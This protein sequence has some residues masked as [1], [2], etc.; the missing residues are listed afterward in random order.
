MSP[1]A[2]EDL[3]A[4]PHPPHAVVDDASAVVLDEAIVK[5]TLVRSPMALGDCLA[6][7]HAMASLAAQLHAWL[8]VAVAGARRQGHG[9]AAIAGQLGT[10]AAA[11]RRRYGPQMTTSTDTR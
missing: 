3:E 4:M 6:D 5:L 11:A 9:W 10:S 8:A 1:G 7:L 2:V